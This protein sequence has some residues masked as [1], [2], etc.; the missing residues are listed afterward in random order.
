VISVFLEVNNLRLLEK[1]AIW[2]GE[3]S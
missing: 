1:S 3:N 2:E